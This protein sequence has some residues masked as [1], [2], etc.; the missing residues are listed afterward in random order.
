MVMNVVTPARISVRQFA[1]SRWNSKYRSR[2]AMKLA[3]GRT[4]AAL[5]LERVLQIVA[6]DEIERDIRAVLFHG[7]AS[8]RSGERIEQ[9]RVLTNRANMALD[10]I[11]RVLARRNAH[12]RHARAGRC[13]QRL[14]GISA[15]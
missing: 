13:G 3:D 6:R 12:R 2:R 4:L 8:G 11:D 14:R 7:D 10:R 15:L 9:D 5:P 1:P